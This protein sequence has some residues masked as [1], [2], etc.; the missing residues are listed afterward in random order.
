[1]PYL[2]RVDRFIALFGAAVCLILTPVL[3]RNVSAYQ[4]TWPLPALYFIELMAFGLVG[5]MVFLRD[6][7][8]KAAVA[9][10]IGGSL[11]AFAVLGAWSVGFFYMPAALAFLVAGAGADIGHKEA[12]A[13]HVAI[14]FAGMAVQAT[15]MLAAVRAMYP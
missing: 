6:R 14:F 8:R 12:R 3:W 2:Q 7:P 10:A 15:L 13:R 1:M 11:T 4:T 5:A 9:W